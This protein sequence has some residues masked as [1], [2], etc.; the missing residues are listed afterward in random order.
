MEPNEDDLRVCP[1]C[2]AVYAPSIERCPKHRVKM[3]RIPEF[4]EW[5][6]KHS[7]LSVLVLGGIFFIVAI[8]D[9]AS[10]A[11]FLVSIVIPALIFVVDLGIYKS[12]MKAIRAQASDF[13]QRWAAERDEVLQT[14][15]NVL[16]NCNPQGAFTVVENAESKGFGG[17]EFDLLKARSLYQLGRFDEAASILQEIRRVHESTYE[18]VQMLALSYVNAD[19]FGSASLHKLKRLIC[20]MDTAERTDLL[21]CLIRSIREN[22]RY[23]SVHAEVIQL[24][25]VNIPNDLNTICAAAEHARADGNVE[26]AIDHLRKLPVDQ[27]SLESLELWATSLSLLNRMDSEAE[28]VYSRYLQGNPS[29]TTIRVALGNIL[30]REKRHE[31]AE[32]LYLAGIELDPENA[33]FRY[34]LALTRMQ[35]GRYEDAMG[36]LQSFMKTESFHSYRSKGDVHRIMGMCM[37]RQ[38]MLN[39]ALKQFQMADKSMQTL[40]RLYE[41]AGMFELRGSLPAAR[42]CYDEIYAE[43]ITYKDVAEKI[44]N[45]WRGASQA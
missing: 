44:R 1:A 10:N 35:A 15:A 41:L 22:R 13:V 45:A 36:T 16:S 39:Q 43:D 30:V 19:H 20:D 4:V 6:P 37:M 29:D 33:R 11:L 38:G 18:I 27:H 9:R 42:V 26:Q 23:D 24:A 12:Q 3:R 40:D 2:R 28:M 17:H 8:L 14:V 7:M 32:F 21:T 31:E 25:L 34:N 5:Y